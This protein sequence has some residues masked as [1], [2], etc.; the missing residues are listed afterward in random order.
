MW[1]IKLVR[2]I[3]IQYPRSEPLRSYDAGY[4]NSIVAVIFIGI[5]CMITM[6]LRIGGYFG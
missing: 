4:A 6:L 2:W 1:Y 3:V 5:V